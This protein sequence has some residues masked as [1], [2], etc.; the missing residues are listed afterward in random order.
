MLY[1][2]M[3]DCGLKTRTE[4][5]ADIFRLG[6]CAIKQQKPSAPDLAHLNRSEKKAICLALKMMVA[7]L[8]KQ[9][10]RDFGVSIGSLNRSRWRG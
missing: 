5:V 9:C 2:G 7:Q 10:F 4:W 6:L 3:Q 8:K 1:Q